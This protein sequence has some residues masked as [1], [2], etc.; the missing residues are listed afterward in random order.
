MPKVVIP[1]TFLKAVEEALI[2][3]GTPNKLPLIT[4]DISASAFPDIGEEDTKNPSLVEKAMRLG[5]NVEGKMSDTAFGSAALV[6]GKDI[7]GLTSKASNALANT[8]NTLGNSA[9]YLQAALWGAD[10]L[11]TV[12][13]KDYRD[14]ELENQAARLE[15]GDMA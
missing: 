10:A 1:K 8:S 13:D 7:L 3:K 5:E 2:K 11:K 15:N 6:A 9:G 14:K 12:A 4:K